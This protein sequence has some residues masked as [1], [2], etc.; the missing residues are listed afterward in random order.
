MVQNQEMKDK[1]HANRLAQKFK[2]Q[3][4]EEPE[5]FSIHADNIKRLQKTLVKTRRDKK[6]NSFG[7]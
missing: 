7:S 6:I 1:L 3:Q 4:F 5:T 2:Q